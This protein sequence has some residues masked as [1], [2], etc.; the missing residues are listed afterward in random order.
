[1]QVDVKFIEL[2]KKKRY[3]Q[4]TAIDDCTRLRVL[5]AYPKHDQKTAIMFIDHVHSKLPFKVEKV[6][7]DNDSEF[8]QSFHWHLLDKGD[9]PYSLVSGLDR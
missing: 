8:G 9:L 3:Y 2:G 7:T 4:D 1:M 6:H 5:M